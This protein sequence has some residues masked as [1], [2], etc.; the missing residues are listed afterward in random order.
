MRGS[1]SLHVVDDGE[2]GGFAV[3][4]DGEEGAACA[5]GAHATGLHGVSVAD[6]GYVLEVDGGAVDDLDGEIVHLVQHARA[7]VELDLVVAV[8]DLGRAGGNGEVVAAA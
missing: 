5:V 8:A 7:A 1:A 4:H 3:A 6:L 2:R